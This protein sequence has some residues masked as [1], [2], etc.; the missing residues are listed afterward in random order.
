MSA[1][2]YKNNLEK[3]KERIH[4]M[5]GHVQENTDAKKSGCSVNRAHLIPFAA[6][7][8]SLRSFPNLRSPP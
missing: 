6:A 4:V 3:K 7:T 2:F 5:E 8:T 1:A